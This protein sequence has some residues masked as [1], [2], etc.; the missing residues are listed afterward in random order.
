M[1]EVPLGSGRL[2]VRSLVP[3]LEPIL[4]VPE[5]RRPSHLF[6]V[7]RSYVGNRC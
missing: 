4:V 5:I 3:I 1:V 2:A 7:G 6:L